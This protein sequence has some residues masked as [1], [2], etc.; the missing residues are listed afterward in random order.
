MSVFTNDV[1]VEPGSNPISVSGSSVSVTNFPATQPVSGTVSA[2][3]GTSPW[4]VSGTVT[5]AFPS[6]S[7]STVTQVT[8]TAVNQTLL[9]A[10]VNRKKVILNFNT[11]IWSVKFG[12]G[13]TATS[14]TY[15][16]SGANTSITDTTWT[17]QID[18]ICTTSGKTVN[19]TELV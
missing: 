5:T 6:S 10:N 1:T 12:T 9:A 8:S 15:S 18:A 14:F 7:T 13:A 4:V 11:G 16:V 3:Q 2:T 17:G 19:V